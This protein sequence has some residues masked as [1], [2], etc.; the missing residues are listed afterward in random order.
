MLLR[1]YMSVVMWIGL[2]LTASLSTSISAG[3]AAVEAVVEVRPI[4]LFNAATGEE[5]TIGSLMLEQ[6]EAAGSWTFEVV[7]DESQFTDKFLSMRPFKCLEKG[8]ELLCHLPYTYENK[9]SITADDLTDLEY[10]LLFIRKA[11]KD[12]GIDP[13][14]G[15]YYRLKWTQSGGLEGQ[16]HEVNLNLLAAPP[17]KGNLRPIVAEDLYEVDPQ[18]HWL[19]GIRIE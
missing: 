2:V 11:A 15:T 5:R 8:T 1:K 18:V 9:Y 13:W 12:Y 17:E 6:D 4:I 3:A 14:D 10:S 7:L 16:L 19:P